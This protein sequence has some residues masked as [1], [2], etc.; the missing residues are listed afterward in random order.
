MRTYLG[1]SGL[2]L[3]C[4][5]EMT[6]IFLSHCPSP[7][8]VKGL[9]RLVRLGGRTV[10]TWLSTPLL[11]LGSEK[12][13]MYL[14]A[15][16]PVTGVS[17]VGNQAWVVQRRSTALPAARSSLSP[18]RQCEPYRALLWCFCLPPPD[19]CVCLSAGRGVIYW[20]P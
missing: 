18:A 14:Q 13:S 7:G 17:H 3:T 12:G 1:A 2:F 19:S 11:S 9:T 20:A 4:L 8:E 5:T 10:W 6:L 16:R 15:S